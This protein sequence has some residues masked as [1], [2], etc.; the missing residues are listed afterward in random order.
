MNFVIKFTEQEELKALPIV[1]FTQLAS[2]RNPPTLR[3][4]ASGERI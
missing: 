2:D 3:G 1:T 4:A